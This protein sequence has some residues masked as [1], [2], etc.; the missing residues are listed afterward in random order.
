M[1]KKIKNLISCLWQ[2]GSETIFV[3]Q[4]IDVKRY[5]ILKK[6]IPDK[7]LQITEIFS[8]NEIDNISEYFAPY[9]NEYNIKP[10]A[11]IY[12]NTVI[13]VGSR[14]DNFGKINYFDFDF[15]CIEL[16]SSL[17]EFISKLTSCNQ[18]NELL[19]IL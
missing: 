19:I 7:W 11:E 12:A 4:F 13:C 17:S 8:R 9:T 16:D 6:E 5:E 3:G 10:F 15:G 14:E 2:N 1:N 18:K